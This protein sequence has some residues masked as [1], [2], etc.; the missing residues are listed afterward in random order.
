VASGFA[1]LSL[2]CL[3]YNISFEGEVYLVFNTKIIA[4]AF[5][6]LIP[7]KVKKRTNTSQADEEASMINQ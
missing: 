6:S 7:V 5:V 1:Y 3:L 2:E 4:K